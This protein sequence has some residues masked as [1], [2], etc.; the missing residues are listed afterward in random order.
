MRAAYGKEALFDH[1]P[2]GKSLRS[3]SACWKRAS[4]PTR[5][6]S[7]TSPSAAVARRADHAAVCPR[8]QP[9]GHDPGGGSRSGNGAAQAARTEVRPGAG[10]VGIRRGA[11]AAGCRRR[12]R[13]DWPDQR[14]HPV[15]RTGNG[16]AARRRRA[17]L[18]DRPEG[19]LP[20]R[21]RTTAHR[22]RRSSSATIAIS[23]RSIRCCSARR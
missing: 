17:T 14:R 1:I 4:R 3:P 16:L 21:R 8:R 10:G 12:D 20:A 23:T 18:G 2:G 9:C 13:G 6:W 5:K 11:V 22:S 19:A 15:R 7:P